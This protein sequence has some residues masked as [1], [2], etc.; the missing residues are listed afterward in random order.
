MILD[1]SA[2]FKLYGG[3]G[4]EFKAAFEFIRANRFEKAAPGRHALEGDMYYM[5][6]QYET[7]PESE[8]FFEAHRA[9]IDLQYM[10]SGRERHNYANI[11]ALEAR[12]AYNAEKDLAVYDGKGCGFVL[13]QGFFVVYFPEDA[14]MPNLWVDGNP[15]S[16]VKLVVKIPVR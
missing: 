12:D 14:H 3:L 5:L 16:V 13:N 11:A 4:P 7:R 15:A 6:Q 1:R 8:G 10:V 2:N 9:Y